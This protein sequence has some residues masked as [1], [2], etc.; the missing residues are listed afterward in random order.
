M[1]A[2]IKNLNQLFR[3]DCTGFCFVI[4][5]AFTLIGYSK[6]PELDY[7][8]ITST[9][10]VSVAVR[11]S[12]AGMRDTEAA[13]NTASTFHESAHI[14]SHTYMYIY[15]FRLYKCTCANIKVGVA[16]KFQK[17]KFCIE[18]EQSFKSFFQPYIKSIK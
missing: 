9:S 14:I 6:P 12:I 13:S 11:F 8:F 4:N 5:V 18:N 15:M 16:L 17:Q 10:L 2:C 7:C 1:D 3:R